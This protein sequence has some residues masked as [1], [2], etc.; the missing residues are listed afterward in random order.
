MWTGTDCRDRNV[1]RRNG[2]DKDAGEQPAVIHKFPA[3]R[4]GTERVGRRPIRLPRYVH[5]FTDRHGRPR[6]YLR[7]KG[8]NKVPLPGLPWSPEFMEIYERALI[9]C[10]APIVIGA[11]RTM[12]GTLN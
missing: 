12:A 5:F 2:S 4:S 8:Q 6:F 9:T 7:R 11:S 3:I 10:K 1:A